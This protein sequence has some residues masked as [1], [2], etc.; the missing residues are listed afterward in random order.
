M[1]EY[2]KPLP[3]PTALTQPFWDGVRQ[4]KLLVQKCSSCGKLRHIPKPW[5]ANC[6]SQEC[7]WV[8]LSGRGQVYSY[9]VMHRAPHTSF[10]PD[11]PF[12]VALIELEEGVRMISNIVGCPYDQVRVG[13][14]VR[15][16]Y[17][18]IDDQAALFK[19]TPA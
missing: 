8:P 15:V 5:C 1:S 13:M 10:T 14:P 6:L 18:D 9:T 3:H 4:H 16:V 11:V 12:A 19:F 7:T 2:Q 17:E